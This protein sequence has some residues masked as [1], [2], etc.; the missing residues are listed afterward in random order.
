MVFLSI[1]I[2]LQNRNNVTILKVIGVSVLNITDFIYLLMGL[3]L[4]P[5]QQIYYQRKL[6]LIN[7]LNTVIL[8]Y[9]ETPT[10]L[11]IQ[12]ANFI[13]RANSTPHQK[14]FANSQHV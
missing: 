1:V 8:H 7:V 6:L 9:M 10:A 4:K 5:L 3:F 11:I 2:Q 12:E 14:T 13:F